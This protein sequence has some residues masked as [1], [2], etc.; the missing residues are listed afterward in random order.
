MWAK[1]PENLDKNYTN[2]DKIKPKLKNLKNEIENSNKSY[3][4]ED[5]KIH[6]KNESMK[7]F[8]D[9][10]SILIKKRLN[11]LEFLDTT[12][13]NNIELIIFSDVCE[14]IISIDNSKEKIQ[15]ILDEISNIAKNIILNKNDKEELK[16][17]TEL[18]KLFNILWLSDILWD[19]DKKISYIKN[20]KSN[21]YYSLE[22]TLN[23]IFPNKDYWENNADIFNTIQKNTDITSKKFLKWSELWDQIVEDINKITWWK[24]A[25]T[26]VIELLKK[27]FPFLW[28]IIAMFLWWIEKSWNN[29]KEKS[30]NNFKKF[31]N[32]DENFPLTKLINENEKE[33]EKNKKLD[34]LDTEKLKKFHKYLDTEW[35]DYSKEHFW[36]EFLTW[37]NPDWKDIPENITKLKNFLESS[38]QN[39]DSLQE[40]NLEDFIKKL[41]W[42]PKLAKEKEKEEL[43]E[44]NKEV[45]EEIKNLKEQKNNPTTTKEEKQEIQRKITEKES[46]KVL[47]FEELLKTWF[48]MIDWVKTKI[49][50][51]NWKN[52]K[53]WEQYYSISI[54]GTWLRSI[55]WNVFEEI[56]LSNWNL[57]IKAHWETVNYWIEK[58]IPLLKE[59]LN[60]WEIIWK[61]ITW[62]PA[63]L[64]I[65]NITAM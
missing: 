31:S 29:K 53:I 6:E 57:T 5:L 12:E 55:A 28:W 39:W 33:W 42:I 25:L 41:N 52:I 49:N 60:K 44:A 47:S 15:N 59:L 54:N 1:T 38:L 34:E 14:K 36:Q 23:N 63:T 16:N 62:K 21:K 40:L 56:K 22:E 3:S 19:I 35:I 61:Q 2:S 43:E 13:K 37:E 11:K 30:I 50:I 26:E 9:L 58:A 48:V 64:T 45:V 46:E 7:S 20:E 18:K 32:D 4:I 17:N 8:K 24:N 51:E 27:E 10:I 65:K